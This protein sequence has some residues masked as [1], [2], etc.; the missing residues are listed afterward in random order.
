MI[1]A[2]FW[3]DYRFQKVRENVAGYASSP[4]VN[5]NAWK[6]MYNINYQTKNTFHALSQ[7]KHFTPD[8]KKVRVILQF[9]SAVFFDNGCT[10]HQ[11]FAQRSA[12]IVMVA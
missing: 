12:S 2:D 8:K 10:I 1:F 7:L 5:F 9:Y 4:Q 11:H 3:D 6:T